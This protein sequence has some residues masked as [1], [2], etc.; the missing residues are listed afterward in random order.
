[1]AKDAVVSDALAE[2]FKSEKETPYTRFLANEGLDLVNG[3]YVP[4]LHEIELKPWARRGGDAVFLNHDASRTT[5]DCYVMEIPAGG[6]LAPHRQLFE[7]T[8][9]ILSGR[10]STLV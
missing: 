9:L 5:N 1:M 4:S 10:G 6:K 8:V 7:E 3:N 2:K